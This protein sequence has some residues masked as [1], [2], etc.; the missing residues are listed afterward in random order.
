MT[1]EQILLGLPPFGVAGSL[2]LAQ[3]C[4]PVVTDM[5]LNP[6]NLI[7]PAGQRRRTWS[8]PSVRCSRDDWQGIG[9]KL[10]QMGLA[11]P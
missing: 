7:I 11:V 2:D 9:Y 8:T 6:V 3:F 4:S 10:L 5:V 1:L